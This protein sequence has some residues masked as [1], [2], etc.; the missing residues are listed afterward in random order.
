MRF[1]SRAT[2]LHEVI[3]LMPK[4]HLRNFECRALVTFARIHSRLDLLFPRFSRWVGI[5]FSHDFTSIVTTAHFSYIRVSSSRNPPRS[6][7]NVSLLAY[8]VLRIEQTGNE[9]SALSP[10]GN[11]W[12]GRTEVNMSGEKN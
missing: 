1:Y 9:N 3:P 8:V 7:T 6:S 12:C 5:L 4:A 11:K 10:D 2:A